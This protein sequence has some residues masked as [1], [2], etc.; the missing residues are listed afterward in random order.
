MLNKV[1]A[2]A[3]TT[4]IIINPSIATVAEKKVITLQTHVQ[5]ETKHLAAS[6]RIEQVFVISNLAMRELKMIRMKINQ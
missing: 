5:N 6:G 3:T 1:I 2:M 4:E